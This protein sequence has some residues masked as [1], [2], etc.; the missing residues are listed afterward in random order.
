MVA[1]SEM[2][3]DRVAGAG[4]P[5]GAVRRVTRQKITG[6]NR[7]VHLA[8]F[9]LLASQLALAAPSPPASAPAT[10]TP[11]ATNSPAAG[12]AAES[13]SPAPAAEAPKGSAAGGTSAGEP[14]VLVKVPNGSYLVWLDARGGAGQAA[15]APVTFSGAESSLAVPKAPEGAKEWT[16]F[17]LDQKTGYSAA[18]MLPVRPPETVTLAANDF[19][20]VHRVRLQV[21]GA[22]EKPV[23]SGTA[24]LTDAGG[25]ATSRVW[26]PTANGTVEFTA[27]R[28]GTA[29]LEIVPSGS[30]STTKEVEIRLQ[31]GE[32]VQTLAVSLPEVTAVVEGAP[33]AGSAPPGTAPSGATGETAAPTA[34][35]APANAAP[36]APTQPLPAPSGGGSGLGT[37]VGFALLAGVIYALYVVGRN[38]GWTLDKGLERLG[39]QTGPEPVSAGPASLRPAPAPA[40]PVD[41]SIC[42][43]CGDRK[44]P[45]TGRCACSLDATA[46]PGPLAAPAIGGSP[47]SGPRLVAMQ[48]AYLGQIFP[49]DREMIVGRDASSDVPLPADSTVSRRHARIAPLDGGFQ[50]VDLGSSNGTFVNGGR[51]T[52]AALR[53]G[54]EVSIGSTRFRFEV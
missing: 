44:D 34:P 26:D 8:L 22:G 14:R 38:R 39:V 10:G 30:G 11:S 42:P 49:V 18:R 45:A 36:A 17:V 1:M 40:P 15:V 31:P 52:E 46:A 5:V 23:A 24:T 29:R 37:V 13:A 9:F 2:G 53:P 19:D 50:I 28:V 25:T 48:G 51:V 54:D 20:R 7:R 27:V 35:T 4:K 12:P 3:S 21:A 43:Y 32:T 33:A 47:G 41:P 6:F 16:L